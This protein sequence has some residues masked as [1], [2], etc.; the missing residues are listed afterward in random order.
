LFRE[1]PFKSNPSFVSQFSTR[2]KGPHNS[3]NNNGTSSPHSPLIH[4]SDSKKHNCV[5]Y[6]DFTYMYEFLIPFWKKTESQ[7]LVTAQKHDKNNICIVFTYK[8]HCSKTIIYFDIIKR[9]III[10]SVWSIGRGKY[11]LNCHKPC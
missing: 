4:R 7:K 10:I 11:C 5:S 2:R 8:N 3:A 6:C 1:R 9:I